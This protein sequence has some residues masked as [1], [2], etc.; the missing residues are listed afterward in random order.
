MKIINIIK[1][2]KIKY[3]IISYIYLKNIKNYV[4]HGMIMNV[5]LHILMKKKKF[6]IIIL[7]TKLIIKNL[8]DILEIFTFHQNI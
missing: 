1:L 7:F 6:N 8:K 4:Y 2:N 5:K 3:V